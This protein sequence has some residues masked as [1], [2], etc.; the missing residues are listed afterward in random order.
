[1]ANLSGQFDHDNDGGESYDWNSDDIDDQELLKIEQ[2]LADQ[3]AAKAKADAKL[4][5]YNLASAASASAIP[6]VVVNQ[7]W[8]EDDSFVFAH[9]DD[10]LD[11]L[12][13]ESQ[14]VP[15][16]A[17]KQAANDSYNVDTS[18]LQQQIQELRSQ[19]AQLSTAR[20]QMQVALQTANGEISIVRAHVKQMTEANAQTANRVNQVH[21]DQLVKQEQARNELQA[22]IESLR[23]ENAFMEH[24]LKEAMT[25]LRAVQ[26]ENANYK[27][28]KTNNNNISMDEFSK[29]SS[30]SQKKIKKIDRTSDLR[31]GFNLTA[32][33]GK[34]KLNDENSRMFRGPSPSLTKVEIKEV[35]KEVVK[36]VDDKLLF[37]QAILNSRSDDGKPIMEVLGQFEYASKP[38]LA[39][40]IMEIIATSYDTLPDLLNGTTIKIIEIVK[41]AVMPDVLRPKL[42]ISPTLDPLL[43]LLRVCASHQPAVMHISTIQVLAV[44]CQETFQFV[45]QNSTT[46]CST[47]YNA[48]VIISSLNLLR[49]ITRDFVKLAA[50]AATD[51]VVMQIWRCIMFGYVHRILL[52]GHVSP[53]LAYIF[54]QYML[55]ILEGSITSSSFGSISSNDP[56]EQALSEQKTIEMI[57]RAFSDSNDMLSDAVELAISTRNFDDPYYGHD[58]F[59]LPFLMEERINIINSAVGL[60]DS[61]SQTQHGLELLHTHSTASSYLACCIAEQVD[62]MYKSSKLLDKFNKARAGL[63]TNMIALLHRI[64]MIAQPIPN[65]RT[66][67]SSQAFSSFG[68]QHEVVVALTRIAFAQGSVFHALI[69]IADANATADRARALLEDGWT[70]EDVNVFYG[71][72]NDV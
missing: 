36:P 20:Q 10:D 1:M 64:R 31:D 29:E 22:V 65:R 21:Q 6:S 61:L 49:L 56:Q 14:F 37:V 5:Q 60:F 43:T 69:D 3:A 19:N 59:N 26:R 4:K 40:V 68:A 16:Q 72:V 71:S 62:L 50:S 41:Q 35:I 30:I 13:Y 38:S 70:M 24:D 55:N 47:D 9:D 25:N 44:L 67:T 2:F 54:E 33:I 42:I 12:D 7:S 32:P 18:S 57:C 28:S 15:Q 39:S 34:K 66:V 51:S 46:L 23:S 52:I 48:Q 11:L 17:D 63:I 58:D 27:Q 8:M 53:K 45:F